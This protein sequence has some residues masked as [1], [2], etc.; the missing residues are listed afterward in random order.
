MTIKLAASAAAFAIATVIAV[1]TPVRAQTYTLNVSTSQVADDPMFKGLLEFKKNVEARSGGKIAVKAFP[2]SQLGS[3]EDIIEQIRAGSG[4]ALVTDGARMEPYVKEFGI[5]TAPYI[6]DSFAD[7]RKF[8]MSPLF[9]EWNKKLHA[10]A[11]FEVLSFNWYQGERNLVTNKP[12]KTPAD[13]AGVRMRTPG[14][15]MWIETGRALGAT[16][17]PLPWSEAYSA[18]SMKAIDAVEVQHPSLWGSRLY[19]VTKYVTKTR[20]IQLVTGLI[21]SAAWFDK[22]PADLQKIVSEEAVKAGD[23]ASKLTIDSL[24]QIEKDLKGKGMT[25]TEVDLKPF[26]DASQAVYDKFGYNDLRKKVAETIAQ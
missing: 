13:M 1:A 7:M 5:L 25:I 19:E 14:A 23:Y 10:T 2:A 15:P 6:V 4:V 12:V 8:S 3:D 18:L 11:G 9:A 26:K 17:T 22:L 20:H 24:D 16:P 21:C